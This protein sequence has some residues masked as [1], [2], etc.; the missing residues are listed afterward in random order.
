MFAQWLRQSEQRVVHR[1]QGM[2]LKLQS[3]LEERS[4]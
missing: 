2:S 3:V 1:E 4:V